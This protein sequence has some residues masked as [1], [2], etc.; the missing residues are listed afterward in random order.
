VGAELNPTILRLS[1]VRMA[2]R[3]QLALE[4][5]VDQLLRRFAS[6]AARQIEHGIDDDGNLSEAQRLVKQALDASA[7]GAVVPVFWS[8]L[9]EDL[10]AWL[11]SRALGQRSVP[12]D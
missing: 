7:Q 6:M 2:K 8:T 5:Q 12:R 9:R 4:A 10:C 3:R 1:A 11:D